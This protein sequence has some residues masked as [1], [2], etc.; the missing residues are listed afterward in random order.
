MVKGTVAIGHVA[1]V[2]RLQ[3]HAG[4]GKF[5]AHTPLGEG[6][7]VGRQIKADIHPFGIALQQAAEHLAGPRRHFQNVI[8]IRNFAHIQGQP[9]GFRM[10]KEGRRRVDGGHP[11]INFAR[12]VGDGLVK[13]IG[14][15]RQHGQIQLAQVHLISKP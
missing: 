9:V 3:Q 5:P 11:I 7:H 2:D 6:G 14:A 13:V 1:R 15:I 10:K 8:A 4:I 12:S